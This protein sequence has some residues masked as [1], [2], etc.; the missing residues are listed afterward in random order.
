MKTKFN[1]G[2]K[3]WVV[4]STFIPSQGVITEIDTSKATPIYTIE[5]TSRPCH[6]ERDY[7][8]GVDEFYCFASI[9]DLCDAIKYYSYE[10]IYISEEV[11]SYMEHKL[12]QKDFDEYIR[13][14]IK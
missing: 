14:Q 12:P 1:I 11:I 9:Q 5:T 13:V 4:A 8:S 3:I 10:K 2:D 7:I 6:K